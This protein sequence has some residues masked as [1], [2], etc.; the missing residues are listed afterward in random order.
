MPS[1]RIGCSGL[2]GVCRYLR[3]CVFVGVD[4]AGLQELL[5]VMGTGTMKRVER[6]VT[7]HLFTCVSIIAW[8]VGRLRGR[9]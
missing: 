6:W 1:A 5:E 8:D 4:D 3:Q 2:R 7:G 9:G